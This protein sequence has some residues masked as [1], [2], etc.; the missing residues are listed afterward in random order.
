[1]S[2]N[3]VMGLILSALG[4]AASPLPVVGVLVILL[5]KRARLGSLMFASA[6]VLGNVLAISLAINF[7]DSVNQPFH[8]P[9]LQY[10]GAVSV[11][12]GLGLALT[13]VLARRGRF[14]SE[15]PAAIPQWVHAVDNLSPVGGALVAIS[16]AMTSPKNLAIAISVGLA[17]Q[18]A[19]LRASQQTAAA[20][21]YVIVASL[22]VVTPVVVYF[23]AGE[24]AEPI[25]TRWK[26]TVTAKAAA[27]MELTLLFFGVALALKGLY[28]LFF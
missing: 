26:S 16:N 11:L 5:T 10:E 1:M 8:G 7:A 27:T 22:S 24:K 6:W 21:L 23:V 19:N 25:L 13:G 28:N 17:I 2:T 3:G 14:R 12:F 20:V 4:V 18:S 15:D 9:D